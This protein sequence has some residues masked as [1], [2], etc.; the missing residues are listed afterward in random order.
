MFLALQ[1]GVMYVLSFAIKGI[2]TAL[3]LV[4]WLVISVWRLFR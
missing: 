4:P 3:A 2:A 1:H